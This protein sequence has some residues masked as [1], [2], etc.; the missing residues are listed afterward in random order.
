MVLRSMELGANPNS[1][2]SGGQSRYKKPAKL[3]LQRKKALC[4]VPAGL[5]RHLRFCITY[6][7]RGCN[8]AYMKYLPVCYFQD[9]AFW[10]FCWCKGQTCLGDW[11]R[12]KAK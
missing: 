8:V 6:S 12:S 4:L 9:G 1:P 10:Y 3:G 5:L 7:V 11:R 2:F